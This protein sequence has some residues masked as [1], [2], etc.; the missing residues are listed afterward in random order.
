MDRLSLLSLRLRVLSAARGSEMRAALAVQYF[1]RRYNDMLARAND[2]IYELIDKRGKPSQASRWASRASGN[3]AL[4]RSH[5]SL[6]DSPTHRGGVATG[7]VAESAMIG[8]LTE[9][10]ELMTD[11]RRRIDR[12][13]TPTPTTSRSKLPRF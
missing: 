1:W 9:L 11:M 8:G 5:S 13:E 6:L 3:A 12:L 4:A 7:S 10:K 2:P